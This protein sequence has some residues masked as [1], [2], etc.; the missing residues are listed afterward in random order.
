MEVR[1]L[2]DTAGEGSYFLGRAY[3][4][5]PWYWFPVTISVKFTLALLVMLATGAVGLI[6][7]AENGSRNCCLCC[8]RRGCI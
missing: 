1:G 6:R 2:V 3:S 7:M 8:C 5:A 4:Q